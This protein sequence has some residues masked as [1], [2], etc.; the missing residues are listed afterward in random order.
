MRPVAAKRSL[1][2]LVVLLA[3]AALTTGAALHGAGCQQ[4]TV[5]VPVRS[6]ERSGRTSFVCLGS[7]NDTSSPVERPLEACSTQQFT[8]INEYLYEDDA[9]NVDAGSGSLPH[10]YALVTQTQRGEVAVIDVSSTQRSVLDQNPVEPGANFLPVGAL[11]T[12]IVS[13]PSSIA[14]FVTVAEIGRAGI[15]AL[16]S[17][18]I[19]PAAA[20]DINADAG[21]DPGVQRLSSWPSCSLPS[22]PGDM[23]LVT[24]PLNEEGLSRETCDGDYDV[25]FDPLNGNDQRGR[26]KLVVAMPALG[27]IAVLDANEIYDRE[28][29]SFE[30]CTVE[31]WLKLEV[32]T[33]GLDTP[34]PQP[35]E[36]PACVNP[37]LPKPALMEPYTAR[38]GGLAYADGTLY[39][40]DTAAP[41]IHVVSM[42][43][44]CDPRESAPLA[45]TSVADPSRVVRTS[46]VSVSPQPTPKLQRFLYATDID[47]GSLMVFDVSSTSTTR[48]PLQRKH[49]EWNPFQPADRIQYGAPAA[50]VMVLQR[51]EPEINP[52]T[53]LAPAGVRCNPEPSAPAC[54]EVSQSCDLG[55]KYVTDRSTYTSGA[56]PARLRGTFAFAALTSGRLAVIDID[57]FDSDCRA[58]TQPSVAA[59]CAKDIDHALNTSAEDSCNAVEPNTPRSANYV[60]NNDIAGNHAPSIVN[61]PQLFDANGGTIPWATTSLQMFAPEGTTPVTDEPESHNLALSV[62]EP[63]AHIVDQEWTIA[64]EGALP[65]FTDRLS[66]LRAQPMCTK[67]AACPGGE[68]CSAN[69]VCQVNEEFGIYDTGARF[70]D[71]GVLSTTAMRERYGSEL[72]RSEGEWAR[73]GDYV[74]IASPLPSDLSAYWSRIELR[75]E[76]RTNPT[77]DPDMPL[78]VRP[79]ETSASGFRPLTY[80]DCFQTYGANDTPSTARDLRIIEAYQDHV[81]L[82]K[83]PE[84]GGSADDPSLKELSDIKCCFPDAVAFNVRTGGQWST[85]GVSSGLF[86]HVV[87]APTGECRE[88]CDPAQSRLNSRIIERRNICEGKLEILTP[89]A[90]VK[91]SGTWV[92]ELSAEQKKNGL[93]VFQNP[94][95]TFGLNAG[96]GGTPSQTGPDR[97]KF[98]R[99]TTLGSFTPLLVTLTADATTASSL[100]PQSLSFLPPTGEIVVTDGAMNGLIFVSLSTIQLSRSFY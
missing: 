8:D 78:C 43:S 75:Y 16:P 74:Q 35:P 36:G 21:F 62:E 56:G 20:S 61:L 90:C 11:P 40:A 49:P 65:G 42:T 1:R 70:C 7:P 4:Q 53:G 95:F 10:L 73:L 77:H 44:P 39:V 63:R 52:A 9:G 14:S 100:Q 92:E 54:T 57:D 60:L 6:L 22:A 82:A 31:R 69:G 24:D 58:P 83:R 96:N 72:K 81:V 79:D 68:T 80:T 2:P 5:T 99:F 18:K 19:R 25:G 3:S 94:M 41:V 17:E 26:L 71:L 97:D 33:T 64:F 27:G 13:T 15:F 98:F 85:S 32:D 45:P 91:A 28:P 47:E 23:I 86:H 51:D 37:T 67:D 29:G 84:P 48:R 93:L 30:P 50:D 88:S 59:G 38:P 34:Q 55:T 76:E 46:R 12:A 89:D 87:A 66:D